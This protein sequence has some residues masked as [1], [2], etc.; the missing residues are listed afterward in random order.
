M[1]KRLQDLAKDAR[2]LAK[3]IQQRERSPERPKFGAI[4]W[5]SDIIRGPPDALD[6]IEEQL[7]I[8]AQAIDGYRP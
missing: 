8:V 1:L 4:T 5:T 3:E 6:K 7:L 2:E